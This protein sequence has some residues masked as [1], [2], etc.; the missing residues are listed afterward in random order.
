MSF[1]LCIDS[2]RPEVQVKDSQILHVLPEC[3]LPQ[4]L[5]NK[6]HLLALR[7]NC[8]RAS[9]SHHVVVHSRAAHGR[10]LE[11]L[12]G[13]RGCNDGVGRCDG[14]DDVLDDPL[15]Q[16]ISHPRDVELLRA[17]QGLRS[18]KRFAYARS[19]PLDR[20]ASQRNQ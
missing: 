4:Q 15:R 13:T 1:L 18:R 14:G 6:L 7:E 9:L 8:E 19:R 2:A 3:F 11:R 12:Q 5:A 10:N 17:L 20:E 16:R